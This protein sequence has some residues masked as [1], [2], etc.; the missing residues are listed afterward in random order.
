MDKKKSR[1]KKTGCANVYY[2][3]GY[4]YGFYPGSEE[5]SFYCAWEEG[6]N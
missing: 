6:V 2:L 4:I 5:M 1:F 3:D